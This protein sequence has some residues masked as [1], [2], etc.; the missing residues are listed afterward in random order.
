MDFSYG[1]GLMTLFNLIG[2]NTV[3]I[4]F[5]CKALQAQGAEEPVHQMQPLTPFLLNKIRRRCAQ[6]ES[7]TLLMCWKA[8]SRWSET[9]NLTKDKFVEISPQKVV[10]AWGRGTKATRCNPWRESMYTVIQGQGTIELA[11]YVRTLRSWDR[12]CRTN[13]REMDRNIKRVLG[14]GFGTH[15]AKR[16]AVTQLFQEVVK[17]TVGIE[18]VKKLAKH[19]QIES[20]LRYN[21][22][23]V[24]TAL[25][26]GT[27]KATAKLRT[28]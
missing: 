7:Q 10:I 8:A 13:V 24:T 28:L 5:F 1:R 4:K 20:L 26:L 14:E 9:A 17:G 25:A 23:P 21:S 12:M 22:N 6:S 15:S 27:G 19:Q 11:Q 18:D 16:G 3:P 2:L